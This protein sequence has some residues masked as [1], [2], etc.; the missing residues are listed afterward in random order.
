MLDKDAAPEE[1]KLLIEENKA[2]SFRLTY[3]DQGALYI[4]EGYGAQLTTGYSVEVSG[5]YETEDAVYIHTNLL[6]PE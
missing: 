2:A 6:G 4:A 1:L 5:L 3:A